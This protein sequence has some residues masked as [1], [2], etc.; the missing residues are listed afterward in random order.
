MVSNKLSHLDK[1][2]GGTLHWL[3]TVPACDFNSCHVWNLSGT[4]FSYTRCLSKYYLFFALVSCLAIPRG[5]A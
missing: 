5:H 3:K 4:G 2:G 1:K